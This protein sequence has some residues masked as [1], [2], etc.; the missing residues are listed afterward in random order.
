MAPCSLKK[1]NT[2]PLHKAR[3][4]GRPAPFNRLTGS[5]GSAVLS[6]CYDCGR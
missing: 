4:K 6:V 3:L 1:I 2:R 5:Q